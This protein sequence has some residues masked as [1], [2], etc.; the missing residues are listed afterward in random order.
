ML[1]KTSKSKKALNYTIRRSCNFKDSKRVE[2]VKE[3]TVHKNK[4]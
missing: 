3:R 2:I 1:K 4:V